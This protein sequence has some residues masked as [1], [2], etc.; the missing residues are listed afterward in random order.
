MLRDARTPLLSADTTAAYLTPDLLRSATFSITNAGR[1]V[2]QNR[3]DYLE[4]NEIDVWLGGAHLKT[5][6]P[7]WRWNEATGKLQSAS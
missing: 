5:G 4:N 6:A 7:I 3:A 1:D 2:L